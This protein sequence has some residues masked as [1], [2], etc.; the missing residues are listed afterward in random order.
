MKLSRISNSYEKK[1]YEIEAMK[2]SWSLRELERRFDS[3]LY[4]R[5]SLSRDKDKVLELSQKGK[6][7]EKPKDLIKD[8]CILEFIGFL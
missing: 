3:V 7:I 4:A 5:L 8:S 1:F 2:N 6:I